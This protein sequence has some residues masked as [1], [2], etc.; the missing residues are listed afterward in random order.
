MAWK[1]NFAY[2][3]IGL[4]F[5]GGMLYAG[6]KDIPSIKEH[7]AKHDIEFVSLNKDMEYLKK[8]MDRLLNK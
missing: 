8:G 5:I 4:V 6:V 1:L 3:I 2:W 7:I